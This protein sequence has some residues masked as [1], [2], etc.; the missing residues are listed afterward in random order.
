MRLRRLL[1]LLLI[2]GLAYGQ[3]L[4]ATHPVVRGEAGP[5][6]TLQLDGETP[7][8]TL[9][10]FCAG[11]GQQGAACK[12]VITRAQFE[13]LANALQPGMSLSLRLN[14]ATA[15]ARNLRMATVAQQRGLDKTP[16]FEEA[17]HYAR[18]QLLAQ[19]LTRA[20]QAEANDISDGEIEE[21]YKKN[22]P[23]FE[24]ATVARILV[25]HAR[26]N[27]TAGET[28]LPPSAGRDSGDEE[29]MTRVAGDIR[30]RAIRG[31]DP[32]KLQIEAYA[33]A[34]VSRT[35][36]NTKLEKVRRTT[37]PPQHEDVMNLKAGDVSEVF[38][39]PGG[40]HF[41]YKMMSK[42]TLAFDEVKAEI[43]TSLSSQRYRD[44]MRSFETDNVFSDAYFV[45]PGSS[46][47]TPQRVR[48][49][50]KKRI[51][52]SSDEPRE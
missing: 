43:R 18:I 23:A 45:P 27:P 34:R 7:V 51:P 44:S 31:E 19:D 32:D 24:E 38:S 49:G 3:A 16:G 29:S 15:Y 9:N 12:T 48:S 13:K 41:I 33:A 30:V 42:R 46:A 35:T 4:P 1:C 11:P 26:Q 22:L 2:N 39:D 6:P 10:G 20:L 28:G 47:A 37:L 50:R 14:V 17:L 36:V 8:I 40:A 25:P 21:Y 52:G 5:V